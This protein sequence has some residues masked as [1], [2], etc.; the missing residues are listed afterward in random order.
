MRTKNKKKAKGFSKVS[1]TRLS[2][3]QKKKLQSD[4]DELL[5]NLNQQGITEKDISTKITRIQALT[6]GRKT[7][8]ILPEKIKNI[9]KYREKRLAA[10]A[11]KKAE[12]E[13]KIYKTLTEIPRQLLD[14]LLSKTI[15]KYNIQ[16]T[17]VKDI[18]VASI[19]GDKYSKQFNEIIDNI[20]EINGHIIKYA[21]EWCRSLGKIFRDIIYPSSADEDE[22]AMI[23]DD[24]S[25]IEM[26]HRNKIRDITRKLL[27]LIGIR[28][29]IKTEY[30]KILSLLATDKSVG[31]TPLNTFINLIDVDWFD[32]FKK[33]DINRDNTIYHLDNKIDDMQKL[34]PQYAEIAKEYFGQAISAKLVLT[35][36][37]D[38]NKI[39]DNLNIS[40]KNIHKQYSDY[41]THHVAQKSK[42]KSN[43]FLYAKNY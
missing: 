2:R 21:R 41:K 43:N 14:K 33:A 29:N 34:T 35:N 16:D 37:E 39:S 15:E 31:A 9:E 26:L 10:A 19:V 22:R 18:I 36:S 13:D 27:P 40:F 6:R 42:K 4:L 38:F 1:S 28:N 8:K 32:D 17:E 5:K 30:D 23:Y 24:F 25:N 7:R 3:T 12:E 20:V 11:K